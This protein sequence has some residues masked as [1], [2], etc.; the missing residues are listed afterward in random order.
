MT[1]QTEQGAALLASWREFAAAFRGAFDTPVARLH[2]NNEYA[3]DC[4]S[5]FRDLDE[6]MFTAAA[7]PTSEGYTS[8]GWRPIA[9]APKDRL[10]LLGLQCSDDWP[11]GYSAAGRWYESI[12]DA[13]DEMGHDGGF[14]DNDFT[15]FEFPRT[16]GPNEYRTDGLQPTHWMPKPDAPAAT[17][18]DSHA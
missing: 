16:F 13:P 4:R 18:G 9:T 12:D 2:Q 5:R 3:E 6:R 11:D 14:L 10:I 7:I 8:D 1:N 17:Q 15:F